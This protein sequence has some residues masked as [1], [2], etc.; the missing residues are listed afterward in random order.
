MDT[1]SVPLLNYNLQ[2]QWYSDSDLSSVSSPETLSP[3]HSMDSS[4]SPSYQQLPPSTPKAPKIARSQGLKSPS[5]RSR[6]TGRANR[7]RSK[8][9]ESASEKEKL[10]MRDLT[11]ALHHLRS[12]LPPSVAPAGQT[13]TKIETLRLTIRYISNLSAQLGLSE[14]ALFQRQGDTSASDASSPDI[15]HYL[16]RGPPSGQESALQGQ[17]LE[18][19]LY[20]SQCHSQDAALHSGSCAFGMEPC[21]QD[22]HAD[23]SFGTILQSPPAAQ[24]SCQESDVTRWFVGTLSSTRIH[25]QR[26]A[27]FPRRPPGL[28][29]SS[30]SYRFSGPEAAAGA[31][32]T[33]AAPQN[34]TAA[35][36]VPCFSLPLQDD[37]FLFDCQ[38]A[39]DKSCE[40]LAFDPAL[41]SGYFSAC[42]S[43]S[44]TSSVDS[45][46]FSP[47]SFSAAGGG[48]ISLDDFVFLN[49]EAAA[50]TQ[51]TQTGPCPKFS[52]IRKK[53]RSRYPDK[54]RQTASEREKLRMRDLTKAMHHLRSYL[55]PSVAPAGQT[56]TKIET[57]RLTIRYIS[58]LSAQLGLSE[59][60]LEQRKS[61]GPAAQPQTLGQFVGQPA[62]AG[63]SSQGPDCNAVDAAQ[64]CSLQPSHQEF[65]GASFSTEM[66]WVPPQQQQQQQQHYAAFSGC[67]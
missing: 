41:D 25:G 62:A 13:L 57:M 18:Q 39:A 20:V 4:L 42:S 49:A 29:V 16:Q 37:S 8:Q 6:K 66:Y 15:G 43:L 22:P 23:V 52:S 32:P 58:Y 44:P 14:E 51:E 65:T 3:V 34:P 40:P 5:R 27:Q 30:C 12:Y 56:L 50:R 60:A 10:R 45:F 36:E 53:S 11:K 1:S 63:C 21:I 38:L 33:L 17:S 55:P 48:H 59:E 28:G 47:A 35:M 67:C 26:A 64:L 19:S 31:H 9:R 46:S 24:S 7:I 2:Y 61:S 54:K